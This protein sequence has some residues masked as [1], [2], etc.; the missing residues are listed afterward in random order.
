M[1][2]RPPYIDCGSSEVGIDPPSAQSQHEYFSSWWYETIKKNTSGNEEMPQ[3]S[4][5]S[6]G[7]ENM[8]EQ[9]DYALNGVMP[10]VMT[11]IQAGQMR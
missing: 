6:S 10:N 1:C 2:L 11:I 5:H 3:F 4:H 8:E 7:L 9:N